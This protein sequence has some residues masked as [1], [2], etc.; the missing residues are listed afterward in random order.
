M[1]QPD[2]G[3]NFTKPRPHR[4]YGV[5]RPADV[6]LGSE[7][8]T[9][10]IDGIVC[11]NHGVAVRVDVLHLGRLL[12]PVLGAVLQDAKRVNPEISHAEAASDDHCVL[13]GLGQL[14]ETD[15]L[16]SLQKGAGRGGE[17]TDAAPAMAERDIFGVLSAT[18]MEARLLAC[19][20]NP[21][22]SRWQ[23]A[24]SIPTVAVICDA[25]PDELPRHFSTFTWP[26][27]QRYVSAGAHRGPGCISAWI[28]VRKCV[29]RDEKCYNT[30]PL[31]HISQLSFVGNYRGFLYLRVIVVALREQWNEEQCA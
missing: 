24:L 10:R 16:Y 23:R 26:T 15:R 5:A 11:S 28:Y 19:R 6:R 2:K 27:R 8:P 25:F 1:G 9:M 18:D 3:P 14:V 4:I 17:G 20:P 29:F 30:Y 7:A 13:E 31:P 22:Y 21:D 12:S